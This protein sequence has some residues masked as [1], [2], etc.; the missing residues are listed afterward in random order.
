M[1]SQCGTINPDDIED[2]YA[3]N[4]VNG[5][6]GLNGL[7]GIYGK[8]NKFDTVDFNICKNILFRLDELI[9][10]YNHNN[11]DFNHAKQVLNR[12]L[13]NMCRTKEIGIIKK[14]TL[15]YVYRT[16]IAED[17]MQKNM[18]LWSLI[19]KCATR[20]M[21]GI[22]VITIL[23]APFP[24]GQ[25]FSC[26]HNCYYCPNE[27]RANGAEDDMPRSYLKKEPAV[28]RGFQNGWDCVRQMNDRLEQLLKCGQELDKL[29]IIIEGGTYTE[30]PVEYLERFHRDIFWTANT[31]FRSIDSDGDV[32]KRRMPLSIQEE[33]IINQTAKIR[34]IGIC[35]ETRP[36]AVDDSWLW[37]FRY[38]GVTRIQIGV[39]HTDNKIL[40]KVNRGHDIECVIKTMKILKDNCFKVD[41]H[42]MPD[43]PN[44]TPDIDKKMFDFVYDS[45]HI[46]PDQIKVYPCEVTPYTVIQQWYKTRKY[47]PY[48]ETNPRDI[49]DVVKYSMVK[50]PPWIRLPRVVRDIPTSYIQAGNMNPNLRQIINDEL[51]KELAK[52]LKP[53]SG[54]SG[55][56][57]KDLRS[58]EIGRHPTYKLQDAKYIWRK[59]SASQGTEYFI[60]LESRDKRVIFGFI[61]LRI[62]NYKCAYANANANANADGMVKQVFPI[63]NGMGLVRELHVY[64]NLIPVGVKHK[65]GFIPGY[66]HKGIGKTL[67]VIAELV[68]L[69]HNCKGIAVISGEGVREYYKKFNYTSKNADTFMIKKY[70]KKYYNCYYYFAP[71]LRFLPQLAQPFTFLVEIIVPILLNIVLQPVLLNICVCVFCLWYVVAP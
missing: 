26:K 7:D 45:P 11:I 31:F 67:L 21:S 47:I 70:E 37:R 9:R 38:W 27:T 29:E 14:T 6:N 54:G 71:T 48:A 20:N 40:K 28:Q 23:T 2:I 42:L 58:R 43:L 60:S 59:Y 34:V 5:L 69:S 65:D 62:P 8:K 18:L 19:Q 24:D 56:W 49:I 63:L 61:R 13:T 35:I 15:L 51:A 64:G 36:D 3:V 16:L 33:M 22:T 52:E 1:A 32:I 53:G 57:C 50:C 4:G 66:Q 39:Q 68:A 25:P 30:Y 12:K 41:I 10:D 17:K 46:Q 44:A 55:L